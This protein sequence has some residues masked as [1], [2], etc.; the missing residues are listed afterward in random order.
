MKCLYLCIN[1]YRSQPDTQIL[2]T[3][4]LKHMNGF[5]DCGYVIQDLNRP[6]NR[7]RSPPK[8]CRVKRARCAHTV[9]CS[10][11]WTLLHQTF[12]AYREEDPQPLSFEDWCI[13]QRESHPQFD[14]WYTVWKVEL[15]LLVFVRS[16]REGNFH[17]LSALA[18]WSFLP[19]T[20]RI[21]RGGFQSTFGTW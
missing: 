10:T 21:T 1:T 2:H 20:T 3:M 13:R 17:S 7:R 8:S 15:L 19:W 6:L 18:P 14:Y 5:N 11:L 9:T 4:S 16:L 12:D